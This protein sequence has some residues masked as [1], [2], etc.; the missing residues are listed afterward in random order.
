MWETASAPTE[1]PKAIEV[2]VFTRDGAPP[3]RRVITPLP[4]PVPVVRAPLRGGGWFSNASFTRPAD[5][6]CGV[7]GARYGNLGFRL[8]RTIP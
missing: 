5:R 1:L 4:T 7:P 3:S 6:S 8:S 2:E